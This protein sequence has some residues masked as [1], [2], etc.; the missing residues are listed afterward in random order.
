M[1]IICIQRIMEK[2]TFFTKKHLIRI[3]KRYLELDSPKIVGILN[4]TPDSFYDGGKYI[5]TGEMMAHVEKMVTDGADIIDI[6]ASSSRPGAEAITLKEE[7]E[8]LVRALD[9][10]R[11]KYPDFPLSVDTCRPEIAQL[12]VTRFDVEII[13]DISAG[14][15][16]PRMAETIA[17]LKVAYIVMHMRGTP[18]DMQKR[19]DYTD[20]VREVIFYLAERI[21]MLRLKGI[22]DIIIDPGFGFSKTPDQNFE[23]LANLDAFKI[24]DCPLLIGVSRKSMIYRTL[25]I[26]PGEA[27]NGTTA[28]HM[29]ALERGVDFLRVHD[30]KETRQ[31]I[32]LYLKMKSSKNKNRGE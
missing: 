22:N 29:L 15:V 7:Q 5:K 12:V 11:H 20:V 1:Q 24:I 30:V 4:V 10:I 32:D 16:D 23:L 26:S 2:S 8:R 14:Q 19:T 27:L 21:S 18:A 9:P 25:G 28:L 31:V 17:E 3:R 13:N 6:G